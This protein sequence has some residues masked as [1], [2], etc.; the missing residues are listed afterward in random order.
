MAEVIE[1]GKYHK[2]ESLEN[3][4]R[5]A[6]FTAT[7]MHYRGDDQRWHE[8]D[9]NWSNSGI[10]ARPTEIASAGVMVSVADDGMR[11]LHPT[12]DR[13]KWV[14]V[15]APYIRIGGVWTKVSL[16]APVRSGG[17]ITWTTPQ[18][19]VVIDHGG[20]FVKLWIELKDPELD[21][22]FWTP[23]NGQFAFPVG[24]N[25]LTRSGRDILD[26]GEVVMVINPPHVEDG[27]NPDDIRPMT[28]NFQNVT[29][30]GQS[31]PVLLMTLPSITGMTRP[32]IDPTL[33]LQPDGAT[34]VDAFIVSGAQASTN[35]GSHAL[36]AAG[37][38]GGAIFRTWIRFTGLS[39][40]PA[41]ATLTSVVFSM[42]RNG[43]VGAGT[44]TVEVYRL[45]RLPVESQI[46]WNNSATA[47]PWTVAGGFDTA[48][49]EQTPI[50]SLSQVNTDTGFQ[51]WTLTPTSVGALDLGYGWLI[52][53]TVETSVEFYYDSS[54]AGTAGNR[55]TLV[56]TYVTAQSITAPRVDRTKQIFPAT[57]SSSYVVTAPRV[58]R[59]KQIF[60]AAL[61]N[62]NTIAPA[63][64]D[65]TKQIFSAA[66]TSNYAI[67][68][69]LVSRTKQIFSAAITS[70]Y[71]ITAPLVSRT[72][73]IFS[74]T[75]FLMQQ[76]IFSGR[77]DR[78]KQIYP[79]SLAPV[80]MPGIVSAT[81]VDLYSVTDT[82][83]DVYDIATELQDI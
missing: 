26:N 25:G 60:P 52:K 55:P 21:G 74:A 6:T 30:G 49:C 24:I 34:G 8:P 36:L 70:N 65:R 4:L 77:L 29:I 16:G 18:A 38:G 42:R 41:N 63:R 66:I 32:I 44:R 5:R 64:L 67:T 82:I 81:I 59:T 48:D 61:S 22:T 56:I 53:A 73:Q 78:V 14:E 27:N 51:N 9:L 57:V 68:A 19:N 20:H 37:N 46:T 23:A 1:R 69:P 11:R 45:K 72:K 83:V 39:A 35:F 79:G 7:P 13:N 3:G 62:L 28:F 17:R 47:T 31:Q 75:L 15:G 50:G 54:D 76:Y 58:D 10:P 12:L 40:I 2:I 71:A 33:S 43:G 80:A